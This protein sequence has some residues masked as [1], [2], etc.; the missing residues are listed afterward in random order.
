[1]TAAR[2]TGIAHC[3]NTGTDEAGDNNPDDADVDSND[4]GSRRQG[5][6]PFTVVDPT[7]PD[8]SSRAGTTTA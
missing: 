5:N 2:D 3:N 4:G 7:N 1:M 8:W 6:E